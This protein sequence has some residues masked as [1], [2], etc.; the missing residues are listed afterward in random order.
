MWVHVTV[1]MTHESSVRDEVIWESIMMMIVIMI[2]Q[3]TYIKWVWWSEL[4]SARFI[5]L[6]AVTHFLQCVYP[7]LQQPV[8]C[9]KSLEKE[10]K[11]WSP[12]SLKH[13]VLSPDYVLSQSW[14]GWSEHLICKGAY[15]QEETSSDVA[16]RNYGIS[17]KFGG[18]LWWPVK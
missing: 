7:L 16:T 10:K 8:L 3:W 6:P 18:L 2:T 13:V 11:L 5:K 12:T 9:T 14:R 4:G 1:G 17:I 15:T